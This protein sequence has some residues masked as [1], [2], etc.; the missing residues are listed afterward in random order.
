MGG[1]YEKSLHQGLFS[2]S[3]FIQH[4]FCFK[5]INIESLFLDDWH[6]LNI[7]PVNIFIKVYT[8]YNKS[9]F[10]AYLKSWPQSVFCFLFCFFN[11]NVIYFFIYLPEPSPHDAGP[12]W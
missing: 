10:N 11:K 4:F 6:K 8:Q 5:S 1:K 9:N 7:L 3:V 2:E 12:L